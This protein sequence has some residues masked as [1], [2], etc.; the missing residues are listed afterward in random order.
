MGDH[1]SAFSLHLMSDCDMLNRVL[2]FICL[3][4]KHHVVGNYIKGLMIA[5]GEGANK[6]VEVFL[7]SRDQV[8]SIHKLTSNWVHSTLEGRTLCGGLLNPESCLYYNNNKWEKSYNLSIGR[9]GHS[10]WMNEE[11]LVLIGGFRSRTTTEVLTTDKDGTMNS[12]EGFPLV[13]ET[14]YACAMPDLLSSSVIITGGINTKSTVTR[15]NM[16]GF[17]EDLP[18]L[19]EGRSSH[20]CSSYLREDGT[21]VFLVAGG[22]D[23]DYWERSSTEILVSGSIAWKMVSP[24]PWTASGL[25]GGTV[26]SNKLYMT[27]GYNGEWKDEILIWNDGMEEWEL[28]GRMMKQRYGHAVSMVNLDE[29]LL[30][31]CASIH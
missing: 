2:I 24:L 18:Q 23:L 4:L 22:L 1:H 31:N 13:Y 26:G 3:V 19:L 5:G 14:Q 29:H 11:G 20:G 15:Y 8:C 10:S 7:P 28:V 17:V 30:H 27:G 25:Q 12:R 16:L 6:T 21:Q 9:D